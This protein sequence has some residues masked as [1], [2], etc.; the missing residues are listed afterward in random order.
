[1]KMANENGYSVIRV[2]QQSVMTDDGLMDKIMKQIAEL[3]GQVKNVCI[4]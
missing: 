2:L 3:E 4:D 1:M